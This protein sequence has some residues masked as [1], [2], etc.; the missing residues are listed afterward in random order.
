MGV[1][2]A[3][4]WLLGARGLRGRWVGQHEHL[5]NSAPPQGAPPEGT[6]HNSEHNCK[7]P[8]AF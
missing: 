3:G 1:K 7:V 8:G 6:S 2:A 4:G 5:A